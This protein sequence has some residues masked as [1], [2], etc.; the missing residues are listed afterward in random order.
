M[1][2]KFRKLCSGKWVSFDDALSAVQN[3]VTSNGGGTE[4][5]YPHGVALSGSPTIETHSANAKTPDEVKGVEI[6]TTTPDG[7]PDRDS[8]TPS[9]EPV[10]A[11]A[12]QEDSLAGVFNDD[13]FLSLFL[14]LIAEHVGREKL[15]VKTVVTTHD[16]KSVLLGAFASRTGLSLEHYRRNNG[17]GPVF[18][19]I[20]SRGYLARHEFGGKR[21]GYTLTHKALAMIGVKP[22]PP[23]TVVTPSEGMKTIVTNH[24]ST[25]AQTALNTALRLVADA[26][27]A[28]QELQQVVSQIEKL[29]ARRDVL[30]VTTSDPHV[31]QARKLLE[32]LSK[33]ADE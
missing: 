24:A 21:S 15:D 17:I 5:S 3:H 11:A 23:T 18:G 7:I 9:P 20:V 2:D 13:Q 8:A 27:R 6:G 26:E 16:L 14:R 10:S 32:L 30:L 28:E 4:V 29:T 1:T 12:A 19:S 22:E 31:A 33:L 25:T